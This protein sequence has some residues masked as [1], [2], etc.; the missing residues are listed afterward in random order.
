VSYID[1]IQDDDIHC[2]WLLNEVSSPIQPRDTTGNKNDSTVS[3]NG[4]V[5]VTGPSAWL[6]RGMKLNTGQNRFALGAGS[7]FDPVGHPFSICFWMIWQSPN[8]NAYVVQMSESVSTTGFVIA[9]RVEGLGAIGLRINSGS[10]WQGFITPKDEW[11]HVAWTWDDTILTPY[12]NGE[13]ISGTQSGNLSPRPFTNLFNVFGIDSLSPVGDSFA[14]F[15]MF[16]RALSPQEVN[17]IYSGPTTGSKSH[18][19]AA[20]GHPLS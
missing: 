15:M 2:R 19:L 17:S 18:P 10:N 16:D 7:I 11:C 20:M 3:R 4:W 5:S 12:L 14:E 13:A 9:M 1:L 6:K 8:K